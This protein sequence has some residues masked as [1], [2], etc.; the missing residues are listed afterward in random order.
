MAVCGIHQMVEFCQE[1][2]IPH[3]IC[4][5]LVVAAHADELPRMREIEPHVGGVAALRVPQEGIVDY[6]KVCAALVPRIHGRVVTGAKARF[7]RPIPGGW[8]VSTS[9][10]EFETGLLVNCAAYIAVV[11]GRLRLTPLFQTK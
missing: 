3:E 6:A 7:L 1:H 2:A 11:H 8:V 9:A 10:G 4:G 5:K